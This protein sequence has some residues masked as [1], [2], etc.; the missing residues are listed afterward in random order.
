MKY[1]TA[2]AMLCLTA[3]TVSAQ[4]GSPDTGAPEPR[5]DSDESR[6]EPGSDTECGWFWKRYPDK[7]EEKTKPKPKPKPKPQPNKPGKDKKDD[8]D[9]AIDC[10][11][12]DEWR[13]GCGFI[14]PGKSYDFQAKQ[15][16]ALKRRMVMEP[17]NRKAVRGFQ[18]YNNWM[19]NQAIAASRMWRFNTAQDPSLSQITDKP[20]SRFGLKLLQREQEKN[21][22]EIYE[23]IKKENGFFVFFSRT[24]CPYCHDMLPVLK[25]LQEDTGVNVH[26]ASLD[27]ECMPGFPDGKCL[28]GERS[29]K[30]AARLKVR[31]VPDL[32][33]YLPKDQT[34]I[35]LATGVKTLATIKDRIK[36]F[37][38]GMEAAYEN[39]VANAKNKFGPNVDF[40]NEA[41]IR[42]NLGMAQ[43]V[44]K[45]ENGQ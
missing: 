35:R 45:S 37:V 36:L 39:A 9:Q 18:E 24:D 1:W 15:R 16:D 17:N 30:P 11:N 10:D 28:T 32:L 20:T 31:T 27:A 33:V 41:N 43:G 29:R 22:N 19:L 40:V 14:D 3:T 7:E 5:S 4:N 8:S 42:D 38:S 2:I 21:T 6:C 23:L 12:P 34:W 26:N 13:P 25:E 44:K